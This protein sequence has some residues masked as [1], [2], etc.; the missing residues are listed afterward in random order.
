MDLDKLEQLDRL[1]RS[2]ALTEEEFQAEKALLGGQVERTPSRRRNLRYGLIG[3]VALLSLG[4]T[5]VAIFRDLPEA[6]DGSRKAPSS[7][8]PVSKAGIVE[9]E[10]PPATTPPSGQVSLFDWATSE[11][12]LGVTPEYLRSKLGVPKYQ[13]RE[14]MTFDV[15]GCDVEYTIGAS[16]VKSFSTEVTGRCQPTILGARLTPRT[17]F[18]SLDNGGELVADCLYSCGNAAD[19]TVDL[20]FPASHARGFIGHRFH[21]KHSDATGRAIEAW[22]KSVRAANNIPEF[23]WADDVFSCATKPPPNVAAIAREITVSW[24]AVGD[25][26]GC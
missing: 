9:Q 2:G 18:A 16:Q 8:L 4:A 14:A 3:M 1:R 19:P 25:I 15:G 23:E 22:E 13:T 11:G 26:E 10:T 20:Y 5:A 6:V 24:V 7:G 12:V 21:G 17:K